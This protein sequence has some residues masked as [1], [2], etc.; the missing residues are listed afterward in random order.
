MALEEVGIYPEDHRSARVTRDSIENVDLV[1]TMNGNHVEELQAMMLDLPDYVYVLP[2][3]AAGTSGYSIPDPYGYTISAH[4][5]TVRQLLEA[6]EI[7]L[8]RLGK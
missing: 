4:R 5:A 6:I 8:D 7:L 2:E 3:Y 1:L